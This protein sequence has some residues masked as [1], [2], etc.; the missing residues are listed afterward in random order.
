MLT[1]GGLH[2]TLMPVGR[3]FRGFIDKAYGS[4]RGSESSQEVAVGFSCPGRGGVD[5]AVRPVRSEPV[6]Q[7]TWTGVV[8]AFAT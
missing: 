2:L 4:V 5:G 8:Q 3:F 7:S 1:G 6:L